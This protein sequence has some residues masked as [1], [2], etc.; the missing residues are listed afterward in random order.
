MKKTNRKKM[1][2]RKNSKRRVSKRYQN[3]LTRR[4]YKKSRNRKKSKHNK[5]TKLKNK[6]LFRGGSAVAPPAVSQGSAPADDALAVSPAP[7]STPGLTDPSDLQGA[8][9][10]SGEGDEVA[11]A[12]TGSNLLVESLE[13]WPRILGEEGG[14]ESDNPQNP[15][16]SS[17]NATE[18][19]ALNSSMTTAAEFRENV[20]KRWDQT[21][22]A[23]DVSLL[24]DLYKRG[25]PMNISSA[26]RIDFA[27]VHIDA[28]NISEVIRS[29]IFM[30]PK[31]LTRYNG[32]DSGSWENDLKDW[33]ILQYLDIDPMG[34]KAGSWDDYA[35]E[36]FDETS[37][38]VGIDGSAYLNKLRSDLDQAVEERDQARDDLR[39]AGEEIINANES[40][41][42]LKEEE[43]DAMEE[44]V[45]ATAQAEKWCWIA[46]VSIVI[47]VCTLTYICYLYRYIRKLKDSVSRY[48]GDA[49]ASA[50]DE[51]DLYFM[52]S[53]TE[54]TVN[55]F[56]NFN[57]YEE[58][59][60]FVRARENR[61]M[62]GERMGLS[63]GEPE[64]EPEGVHSRSRSRSRSRS[65]TRSQSRTV[66][67]GADEFSHRLNRLI[68][69]RKDAGSFG[70]VNA[71]FEI[72]RESLQK[73]GINNLHTICL[74][75]QFIRRL[76]QPAIIIVEDGFR[77]KIKDE[78][79]RLL[80]TAR[81]TRGR[82]GY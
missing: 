68:E 39:I 28:D 51:E 37:D 17:T 67:T 6:R 36:L 53:K 10:Y 70:L 15:L 22:T 43:E 41:E 50:E 54:E 27:P 20:R 52:L 34:Q 16:N 1:R 78:I 3:R 35:G 9:G 25:T 63:L 33:S 30:D 59:T 23:A 42:R 66:R 18:F 73:Q 12:A 5:K 31:N 46:L 26:E 64:P 71:N 81:S 44:A 32:A 80:R 48:S 72:V 60:K 7:S 8:H 49:K 76:Y 4:N 24:A 21:Q 45:D 14:E 40:I 57:K 11:A 75:Y 82:V 2:K 19:G 56:C 13:P 29:V 62:R 61:D 55:D 79:N 38:L 69:G 58:L 47:C 65:P 74:I 77:L